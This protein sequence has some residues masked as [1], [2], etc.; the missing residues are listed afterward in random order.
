[1][2]LF[3]IIAYLIVI[4][5]ETRMLWKQKYKKKIMFYLAMI[6]F[7]MIISILLSLGVQL[8]SPSNLI[9]N[10]VLSILSKIN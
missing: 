7:S 10:I 2:F 9:K 1:M 8:P 4:I 6:I 5:L 3:V